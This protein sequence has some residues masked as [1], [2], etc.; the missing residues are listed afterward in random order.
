MANAVLEA[1]SALTELEAIGDIMENNL[2]HLAQVNAGGTIR[3]TPESLVE[4]N[5]LHKQVSRALTSA[6]S[7]FIT[8]SAEVAEAVMGM[9]EEINRTEVRIRA[10]KARRLQETLTP[11]KIASYTMQVD[12]LENLKRIYYHAK[13]VAKLVVREDGA[14]DWVQADDGMPAVA[15]AD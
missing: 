3:I 8:E 11:E 2:A 9:K 13:R 14:A 4:L 5:G 6:L 15:V 1:M 10:W 7:A 12:T